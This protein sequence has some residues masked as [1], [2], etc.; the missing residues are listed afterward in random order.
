MSITATIRSDSPRA[1]SWLA[2]YGSLTVPLRSATPVLAS[3]P[4]ISSGQFYQIDLDALTR[5]QRKRLV[6]HLMQTFHLS[7]G[8]VKAHLVEVGCPLLADDL[9][10]EETNHAD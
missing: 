6:A 3:A 1:A 7:V 10:I 8:E 5:E 2:V 9:T 4:G